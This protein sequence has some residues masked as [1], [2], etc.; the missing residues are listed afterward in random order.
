MDLNHRMFPISRGAGKNLE[1]AQV[2]IYIQCPPWGRGPESHLG[3]YQSQLHLSQR[4]S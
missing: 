1:A 3:H 4:E 2:P